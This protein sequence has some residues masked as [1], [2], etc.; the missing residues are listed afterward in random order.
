[1]NVENLRL[2]DVAAKRRELWLR[3]GEEE[4]RVEG[5]QLK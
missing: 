5:G 4:E 2:V 3:A 1:V